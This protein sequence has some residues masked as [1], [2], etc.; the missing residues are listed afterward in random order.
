MTKCEMRMKVK[1]D[2]QE[3]GEFLQDAYGDY[4]VNALY[5]EL[6]ARGYR[7]AEATDGIVKVYNSDFPDDIFQICYSRR[8][9][10]VNFHGWDKF[11][12]GS[13]MKQYTHYVTY[14]RTR[15]EDDTPMTTRDFYSEEDMKHFLD[16]I[17]EDNAINDGDIRVYSYGR[18]SENTARGEEV[19]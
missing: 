4:F 14:W 10:T 9:K 19:K 16:T 11:E 7:V 13:T 12:G 1:T 3:M 8:E 2:V 15:D 18:Y 6:D 17:A 5:I